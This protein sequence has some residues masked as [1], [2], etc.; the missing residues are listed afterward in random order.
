MS[1]WRRGVRPAT[2][3][4]VSA[5]AAATSIATFGPNEQSE[6]K[7]MTKTGGM[8]ARSL[9]AGGHP[10][11]GGQHR[12][13]DESRH[14]QDAGKRRPAREIRENSRGDENGRER[15]DAEPGREGWHQSAARGV[16]THRSM[17]R[18]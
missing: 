1:I 7:M 14:F 5:A 15:R 4:G 11:T 3:P 10:E 9:V 17:S 6:L 16:S 8:M 13:E 18:V 2:R 12:G